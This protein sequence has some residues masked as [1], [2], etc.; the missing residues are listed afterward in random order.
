MS[1]REDELHRQ[2]EQLAQQFESRGFIVTRQLEVEAAGLAAH[3]GVSAK[4]LANW[5][6]QQIGPPSRTVRRVAWYSCVEI[7]RWRQCAHLAGR[8]YLAGETVSR[9]ESAPGGT[10]P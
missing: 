6:N 1:A 10:P 2:A 7:V 8:T 3:V 9:S 4:T 5:R